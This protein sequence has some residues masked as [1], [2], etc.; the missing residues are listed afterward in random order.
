MYSIQENAFG[1]HLD[2]FSCALLYHFAT[3]SLQSSN[4][5][6]KSHLYFLNIMLFICPFYFFSLFIVLLLL[7]LVL[8]CVLFCSLDSHFAIRHTHIYSSIFNR[9]TQ[10][11]IFALSALF[12]SPSIFLLL[13]SFCVLLLILFYFMCHLRLSNECPYSLFLLLCQSFPLWLSNLLYIY[14]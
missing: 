7:L 3:I 2:C 8:F 6:N 5:Q 13:P 12:H 1:S 9:Q 11:I 10:V 4:R 14:I